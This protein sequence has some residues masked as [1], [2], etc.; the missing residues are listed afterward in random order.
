MNVQQH[1]EI[2]ENKMRKKYINQDVGR[3]PK[4]MQKSWEKNCQNSI[5]ETNEYHGHPPSTR[6]KSHSSWSATKKGWHVSVTACDVTGVMS[7]SSN[8]ETVAVLIDVLFTAN[9]SVVA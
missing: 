8:P 4:N 5:Y 1:S 9:Y 6:W 2:P 3:Y 7:L